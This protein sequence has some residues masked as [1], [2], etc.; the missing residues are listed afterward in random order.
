MKLKYNFFILKMELLMFLL[1]GIPYIRPLPILN[2]HTKI[3]FPRK[4]FK[5]IQKHSYIRKKYVASPR[6]I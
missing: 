2:V 3:K 1:S 6:N 5:P 4:I